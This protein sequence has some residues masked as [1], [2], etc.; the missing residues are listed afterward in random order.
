MAL[1]DALVY[2]ELSTPLST[3][4]F[5]MNNQGEIYG[6]DHD[7]QRFRQDWLHPVTPVKGLISPGRMWCPPVSVA[8]W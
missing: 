7:V 2:A 6:L 8:R 4:F 3:A 5:Q 1:K